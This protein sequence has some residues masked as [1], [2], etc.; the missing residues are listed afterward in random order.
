MIVGPNQLQVEVKDTLFDPSL[1]LSTQQSNTVYIRRGSSGSF[2][3]VW[4][5]LTGPGLPFVQ[6]VTYKL[7][8]SFP[9]P[10]IRVERSLSNPNC[11]AIIWT[12]GLFDIDVTVQDRFGQTYSLKY[13]LRYDEDLKQNVDYKEEPA[14]DQ[15]SRPALVRRM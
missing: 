13:A 14:S 3:K 2:Y 4:L 15:V 11:Q 12:W 1:P 10:L 5:Y 7:H 8:P 6:F 9:D